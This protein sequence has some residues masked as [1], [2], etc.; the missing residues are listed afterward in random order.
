MSTAPQLIQ[1][2]IYAPGQSVSV[3]KEA[4]E[5]GTASGFVYRKVWQSHQYG[6]AKA[7]LSWA[8]HRHFALTL[9]AHGEAQNNVQ[10]AGLQVHPYRVEVVTN[11]AGSDFR[12]DWLNRVTASNLL[13]RQQDLL[14][15][16]RGCLRALQSMHALGVLHGDFKAD[17]LCIYIRPAST[18]GT[19]HLDLA[20]LRLIY[21][22]YAVY[23][24]RPL[25]FLLPTDLERLV[26]LL[27]FYRSAIR[28]AYGMPWLLR[29]ARCSEPVAPRLC[30]FIIAAYYLVVLF[31]KGVS[32]LSMGV[33]LCLLVLLALV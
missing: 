25:K 23:Q 1:T 5:G 7:W 15:L 8:H 28:Q 10:V 4:L 19:M 22:A 17:N 2:Q 18:E 16:V 6:I 9:Q 24:A 12:R 33:L 20:S 26:S 31:S 11:D 29:V 27:D 30:L 32:A 3:W 21:F 14:K 13:V